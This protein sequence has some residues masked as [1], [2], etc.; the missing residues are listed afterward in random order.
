MSEKILVVDDEKA[1]MELM[2]K[3]LTKRGYEVFGT[4]DPQEALKVF[5][6][7]GGFV[8]IVTDWMMPGMT[9]NEL[10]IAAQEI[11]PTIQAIVITA[12]G[13]GI[14]TPTNIPGWGNFKH[15]DKPLYNI[16]D[17]SH[18]VSYAIEFRQRLYPN[19][20]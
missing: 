13:E 2:V 14:Q 20:N 17:L 15:L 12:Y 19:K 11:D 8:V 7:E 16:S 4:I 1:Y 9:G 10:I 3:H 6:E 18:A 5:K